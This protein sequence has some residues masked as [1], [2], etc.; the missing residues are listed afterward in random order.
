MP[1]FTVQ[2]DHSRRFDRED[3]KSPL[4]YKRLNILR[5]LS[6]CISMKSSAWVQKFHI[7][8]TALTWMGFVVIW[9]IWGSYVLLFGNKELTAQNSELQY[10]REENR[11]LTERNQELEQQLAT[12]RAHPEEIGKTALDAKNIDGE[13]RE[14]SQRSFVYT[15][16]KGDTIWDIVKMYESV[17]VSDILSLNG[18]SDPQKIQ[19]G[20]KIKIK[21]KS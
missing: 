3:C 4:T 14:G 2:D 8:L 11:R 19:V 15:V 18:I 9:A 20:Q 17:S 21:K 13:L 6:L 10:F 7:S 1:L 5:N 12:L 16:K